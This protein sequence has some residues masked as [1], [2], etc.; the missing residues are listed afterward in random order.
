MPVKLTAQLHEP[1]VSGETSPT[2][3]IL[4]G[5]FGSANNWRSLSRQLAR[6][7]TVHALDLRNHGGSPH[8]A[9]MNYPEM[10]SDVLRYFDEMLAD[11][12]ILVG[13]SMGGKTAMH[14][15]LSAGQRICKLIVV[16]IAPV[17]NRHDFDHLLDAMVALDTHAIRRR[18]EADAALAERIPDQ[19][20]RRFLL[21]EFSA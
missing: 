5:L 11:N 17:A 4:H 2:L 13:H 8:I 18:G 16:D 10:A 9:C 14:L 7:Y 20:L 15:A 12:P 6:D 21:P 19:S 3:V 1:Q